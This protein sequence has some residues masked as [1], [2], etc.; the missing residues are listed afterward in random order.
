MARVHEGAIHTLHECAQA[1]C[2][3]WIFC[4]WC[5]RS[6]AMRAIDLAHEINRIRPDIPSPAQLPLSVVERMLSC[7]KCKM[8]YALVVPNPRSELFGRHPQHPLG[9]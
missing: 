8:R 2:G 5:G 7:K 3:V 6:Q 4:R 1:R 9:Q